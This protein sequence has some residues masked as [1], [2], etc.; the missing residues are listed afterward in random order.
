MKFR[1]ALLIS[2]LSVAAAQDS[3]VDITYGSAIKLKVDGSKNFLRSLDVQWNGRRRNGNIVTTVGDET[4]PEI[5]WVVSPISNSVG[6]SGDIVKC[7]S[8]IRLK[9][10]VTGKEL[11]ADAS[12]KSNL[13]GMSEVTSVGDDGDEFSI[14]CVASGGGIWGSS[15]GDEKWQKGNKIQLKHVSS[16]GY[17]RSSTSWVYNQHNCARCPM[18]GDQEVVVSGT[19]GA[20]SQWVVE[21]GVIV[22]NPVVE[23]VEGDSEGKDEL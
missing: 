23:E 5:Y 14:D 11:A 12:Q 19:S 20:G 16:G 21:G 10:A 22:R 8:V 6:F 4:N 2:T 7:G 15:G 9:H 13:A 17:L 1:K 18:I 3:V